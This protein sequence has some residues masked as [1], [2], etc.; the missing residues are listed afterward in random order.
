MVIEPENRVLPPPSALVCLDLERE[1]AIDT[2]REDRREDGG[3]YCEGGRGGYGS[4]IRASCTE[5]VPK[6]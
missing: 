4:T 3:A 5:D 2:D 1:A 6:P